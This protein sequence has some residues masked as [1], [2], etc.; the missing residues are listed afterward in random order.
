MAAALTFHF[1][2]QD[3]EVEDQFLGSPKY[4]LPKHDKDHLLLATRAQDLSLPLR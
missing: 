4:L 3:M 1:V 2:Q